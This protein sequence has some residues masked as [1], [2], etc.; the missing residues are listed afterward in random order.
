MRLLL[1]ILLLLCLGCEETSQLV[2]LL[3]HTRAS[4]EIIEA[5]SEQAQDGKSSSPKASSKQANPETSAS[6]PN[7]PASKFAEPRVLVDSLAK[8]FKVSVINKKP[9]AA[10][11]LQDRIQLIGFEDPSL[12]TNS[13]FLKNP[14]RIKTI[15][16]CSQ[17]GKKYFKEKAIDD[18]KFIFHVVDLLPKKL[19]LASAEYPISC[20]FFFDITDVSE[21]KYQLHLTQLPI[22]GIKKNFHLEIKNS[23]GKSFSRDFM[24]ENIDIENKNSFSIHPETTSEIKNL[25]FLCEG[26]KKD[27]TLNWS[28]PGKSPI[29]IFHLVEKQTEKNKSLLP[30]GIKLCRVLSE[31]KHG[32]NGI[33]DFFKVNFSSIRQKAKN[34]DIDEINLQLKGT[35]HEEIERRMRDRVT[36]NFFLR[37]PGKWFWYRRRMKG[38]QNFIKPHK[39]TELLDLSKPNTLSFFVDDR[40]KEK[41]LESEHY[42]PIKTRV[43]TTCEHPEDTQRILRKSYEFL[44]TGFFPLM[45][46]TPEAIF[47]MEHTPIHNRNFGGKFYRMIKN[48]KKIEI[49]TGKKIVTCHYEISFENIT[50][51]K[52]RKLDMRTYPIHWYSGGLGVSFNDKDLATSFPIMVKDLIEREPNVIFTYLEDSPYSSYGYIKNYYKDINSI[53]FSCNKPLSSSN[54]EEAYEHSIDLTNSI[55]T[56]VPISTFIHTRKFKHHL[57][58]LIGTKCRVF[59]YNN[60]ILR[61]FSNEIHIV[62]QGLSYQIK[63][64][65]KKNKKLRGVISKPG[66]FIGF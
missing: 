8:P 18:Y 14:E 51:K 43:N 2:Q 15:T 16:R 45:S 21:N 6:T 50:T 17:N 48:K 54:E 31:N 30:E 63:S 39:E 13:K 24:E 60:K 26:L 55:H 36:P 3:E 11:N 49:P 12:F 20:S 4:L 9:E 32:F 25:R 29:P 66:Y 1:S 61:F 65:T 47:Q 42:L 19:L 56:F 34:I 58:R 41:F 7:L 46:V 22:I 64:K 62:Y 44:F 40:I 35:S 10:V 52:V 59:L 33:T 38:N 37:T 57:T 53:K 23:E 28:D 5:S 27:I